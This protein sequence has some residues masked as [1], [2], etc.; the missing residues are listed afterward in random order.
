MTV[1]VEAEFIL[2]DGECGPKLFGLQVLLNAEDFTHYPGNFYF[3]DIVVPMMTNR[4]LED[5][6]LAKND[7]KLWENA[8]LVTHPEDQ[9]LDDNER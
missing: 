3:E 5:I 7:G 1:R 6:N 4:M 8:Y 2:Q 9:G